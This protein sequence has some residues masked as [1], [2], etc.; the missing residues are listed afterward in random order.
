MEELSKKTFRN[1]LNDPGKKYT[2]TGDLGR[3][4]DGKLFITGRIKDLVI[5]TGRNIYCSDVEKTVETSCEL[6]RPGCCAA[7]AVPKDILLSKGISITEIS[8]Q[9]GL[10]VI[11][12]VRDVKSFP[13]EV[14]KQ[15]QTCVAEEHGMVVA[16]VVL[17]KPKTISK[18]TSGKIKRF[19]CLKRYVDETL[20][21]VGEL[22]T[23]EK[24]QPQ[25]GISAA[26]P[27]RMNAHPSTH[28]SIT[29]TDIINFLMELLSQMTGVSISNISTS[30]SLVSYGVDSIGV[31]RA[32]QKLSDFLGVP[33]GAIDIF[34]ATCINDLADFAE[35]LLKKS[36]SQSAPTL[37]HS[38]NI[39]SK[40]TTTVI[41]P[42][43]SRKLAIWLMQLVGLAYVSFLML[44]PAYISISKF[45]HWMSSSH[46][47]MQLNIIFSYFLPLVCAPLSWMLCIFSTCICIAFLGTPFLQPNYALDPEI[48]IWSVTFVK[49]WTLYKVQEVSS[50]V[51]A[52]HLRGTVFMNYWFRMLGA[53][54]SSSALID[55]TDITDPFLV[56]IGEAAILA[57]GA[58][59]QSHEVK[60]GMLSLNPIKIGSRSSVGPY[61]CLQKGRVVEDG[62]EVPALSSAGG[63]RDGDHTKKG[64]MVQQLTSKRPENYAPIFHLFGIY[65]IGFL[66]S[67]SAAISYF[68][69]LWIVQRPPTP[70]HF[71]FFCLSGSYHWFPYTIVAYTVTFDGVYSSATIFAISIAMAYTTH[72]LILSFLTCF[73][74]SY[75]SGHQDLRISPIKRWFLHR[76]VTACHLRFA[77]FLSGTE[78]FCSYLRSMGS[79]VGKHCSV[80]AINPV[81]DPELI[82]LADGVHLGDFSRIIPGYYASNGY[83]S[84]KI[85]IQDNSVVGSHGLILP[86]SVLEKD[87]ILGALSL[88]P[89]DSVLQRG[90][91]FVGSTTPVMV[92]NIV[93]SFDDRIEEMDMK[94]KKVLGNLAANFAGS[95]LKVGSRYFHRIGAA[96]KGFLK[97]YD[98]IPNL[99][100]HLIFSPGKHYS[101]IMRHS[102]CLSSDD[103]ARL[104]PRGAAI[105]ILSNDPKEKSPLLD[106]T[107]KTGNAFHTRTIGDFVA[108][109][110]CGAAAREEHVKHAP[111]IRDAMWSSLR[112]AESYTMLHYYSNICRLFRFNNGQEMYV[113]FKLRPLDK[114]FGEDTGKVEPMGILPPETGAIPRDENDN[115]PLLFLAD[116]F[117]RRLNS[118]ER[119]SYVLQLQI[120]PV[121]DDEMTRE[122]ALDCTKPWDE[123]EY[124]H[125][126]VGEITIDQELTKEQ[127]EELEFNPYLRC[128]EVDVIHASSCNQSASMDHGRSVVYAICQ[129]LRNKKPLPEAWRIFLNQSDVKVD[130]TGCPMAASLQTKAGKEV[131]LARPWY[132]TLWL[133]SG[134]P[135]I[136]T[137]L[138]YFLIGLVIFAPLNYMLYLNKISKIQMQWLLPIFWICS[139]FLA[140][141]VCAVTK[142]ILVGHKKEG[143][144]EPIWS[145]G[146]F[147]DTT[148]QA[149]RTLVGEYYM[150]MTSGSF[151]FGIWMKLL[152][153]KVAWD[154]GVYVDSLGAVL[155]PELVEVQEHG[156]V[157]REALLFGHIYEGE[158]GKVKYGKIVVGQGGFVGSRAVAM[159]G[160]TVGTRGSLGAL[161]LAMKE[162]F[163]N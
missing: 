114:K 158:G 1:E 51:L 162:E 135:F 23:G 123:T 144:T 137:F 101:I 35:N 30:E 134:Q 91:V 95:T 13:N 122:I 78:A 87:V 96:G 56:S 117:K 29:K 142:W 76:I 102:N 65:A 43:L 120:R 27:Q 125:F 79:K 16:S 106:L 44:F 124:P 46:T 148:W 47:Q 14:I 105:R 85:N 75:I 86:G 70:H 71:S 34:T 42:S 63:N 89:I 146:I 145:I 108:W 121:P 84:G 60:N 90:G 32:A 49:W 110:V 73:L 7:I 18:T 130:L 74:K 118:P 149:I 2:R 9:V 10:V 127:S 25:I 69:Y 6:L 155:N 45:T 57:E 53:K 38:T 67:L 153:S 3:I 104:D 62:D 11:A 143:E 19:E 126:D 156:C 112:Q 129:H 80:R 113:K 12:E 94:Y 136:Q 140:G 55:T 159:P 163:I 151:F 28:S 24:S 132:V 111:H 88:A 119:V 39:K 92:K 61:A 17:I 15:I 82:S 152:G 107:L 41:E 139:G 66:S 109:L 4:I 141:L 50:K 72:G 98:Q 150:E 8:D 58:L 93:H 116:D 157:E 83:I 99:P 54:V 128:N 68:I 5:I 133:M 131:T 20:D 37:L 147:M 59:L 26:A 40:A 100:D 21:I 161:S 103:D 52:V 154:R 64:E 77:K 160:V 81:S 97:F 115:R 33:V 36:H 31:V 138:P 48:S 22:V